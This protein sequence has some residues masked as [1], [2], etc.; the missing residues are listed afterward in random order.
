MPDQPDAKTLHLKDL[1]NKKNV[2]LFFFPKAMTAGC[3]KESCAF[4]NLADQFAQ[5]DTVVI[6]ISTDKLSAQQQFTAKERLSFPLYADADHQAANSFG[7]MMAGQPYARR[8]TFVID[9][10]GIIRKVY[11]R[12]DPASHPEQVLKFVRDQLTDK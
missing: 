7:V 3:T 12:V 2:V 6:G 8:V 1:E 5:L 11:Q 9:K 4:R 10:K